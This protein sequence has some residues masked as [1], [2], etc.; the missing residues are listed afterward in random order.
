MPEISVVERI[1]AL[2]RY[3]AS[4][5]LIGFFILIYPEVSLVVSN[6]SDSP[7]WMTGAS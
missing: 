3:A 6:W 5:E 1:E 7:G 2:E 4:F